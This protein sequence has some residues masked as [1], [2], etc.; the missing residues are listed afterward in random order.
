[1]LN[2][3]VARADHVNAPLISRKPSG[4][5]EPLK[6]RDMIDQLPNVTGHPRNHRII[7]KSRDF[8]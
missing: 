2:A 7:P 3:P 6:P 4:E 5:K 8:H 1:M